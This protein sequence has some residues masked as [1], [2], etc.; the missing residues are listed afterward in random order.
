MT[1]K[2]K[3]KRGLHKARFPALFTSHVFPF[4][5]MIGLDEARFPALSTSP[6]VVVWSWD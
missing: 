4:Q 1:G 2:T 3:E 6:H 5:D